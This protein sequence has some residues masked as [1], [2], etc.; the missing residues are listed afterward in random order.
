[1]SG[2]GGRTRRELLADAAKGAA[3]AS[4]AGLAGCF[5]SGGGR[6]PSNSC[7][8]SDAD[9]TG[10]AG[11]FPAVT[12]AVVDVLR[13]D[14]VGVSGGKFVTHPDV[15][16]TMV[17]AGLTAISVSNHGGNNLDSTPAPIRALPAIVDALERCTLVELDRQTVRAVWP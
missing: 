1:M 13:A 4:L 3:A 5:P 11:S 10:D 17:D 15:V 16:A 9:V 12:P 7:S 14:S 6:W 8:T 2:N